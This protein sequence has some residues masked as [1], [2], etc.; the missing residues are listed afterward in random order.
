[1]IQRLDAA[2]DAWKTTLGD[3]YVET[4]PESR[5]AH[6]AATFK[7]SQR[8]PVILRPASREEV[9]ACVRIANQFE[10]PLYV[11]STGKN[12]GNGSG[13]PVGDGCVILHL[14]RLNRIRDFNP[15]QA[16]V[17]IE[18]GVTQAQ[19][20]K[21][22]I[23][24]GDQLWVDIS[25]AGRD[26]SLLG[27]IMERGHGHSA[28]SNRVAHISKLGVV[29]PQGDY[30]E[31]GFGKYENNQA[32]SVYPWG[33]GPGLDGLFTQSNL[34]VVTSLTLWLMPKPEAFECFYFSLR[35]ENRFE[36]LID[37]L[38]PLR[39]R[40]V[41]KS[42]V[43]IGNSLK[44][45]SGSSQYPWSQAQGETPLSPRLVEMGSKSVG[46]GA[47]NGSG[48]LYGTKMEI[49]AA[50][51]QLKKALKGKVASLSFLNDKRLAFAK[52]F[53]RLIGK[54]LGVD[55]VRLLPMMEALYGMQKGIPSDIA[56]DSVYWRKQT[57]PSPKRDFEKDG[58]GLIWYSTM[59]PLDG[60]HA[61]AMVDAT[62]RVMSSH[63][64]EPIISVLLT[65]ERSL[66]CVSSLVYDRNIEGE[67]E[68]AMACHLALVET[69][70]SMGYYPYRLG[71]QNMN[72]MPSENK[73]YKDTIRS[74]KHLF[75]PN[76]I[77]SPGRY[78]L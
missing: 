56:F 32:A 20:S 65:S 41:L 43:H 54:L 63:R 72:R 15:K 13:V 55:L 47:W 74:I 36:A 71:I 34:G 23:Q 46:A 75:D 4:T 6:E 17:S 16:Y 8:V 67:D 12:W 70:N 59:A 42:G 68:R 45:M 22:L 30:I 38:Q 21:F 60:A 25:G 24:Q 27:N 69:M 29:L 40:G 53:P 52:R 11:V 2:V 58:C 49:Q 18:P 14:G 66:C 57:P 48:A 37:A 73:Q 33:V 9:Q 61:R 76:N 5:S 3:V 62:S 64:Y 50:K 10:V 77:L 39:L 31:T 78:E 28:Y 35:E 44:I 19:L 1:M 51:I 26:T 7:T